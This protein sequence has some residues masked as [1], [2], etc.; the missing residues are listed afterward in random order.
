M[1]KKTKLALVK[2]KKREKRL[3][4]KMRALKTKGASK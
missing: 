1:Y 4:A 2:H 3:K